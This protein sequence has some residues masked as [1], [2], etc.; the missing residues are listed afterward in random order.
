MKAWRIIEPGKLELADLPAKAASGKLV[1]IKLSYS[2]LSTT[3]RLVFDGNM[4]KADFPVTLGRQGVGMVTAAGDEVTNVSRGDRV[5]ADPYIVCGACACRA[6]R[7]TE[8]VALKAYGVQEDGFLSD[9]ALVRSDDLFKLPDRVKDQ[10]AVF[11]GHTALAMNAVSKLNLEKGEH[12]VIVGATAVG[13]ILAQVAMY[14]QAVPILVDT[15]ADRLAIAEGLGVYY[16]VNSVEEDISK[17]IFSLTG[18]RMAETLCYLSFGDTQGLNRSLEYVGNCGR[19]AIVGWAG[20]KPELPASFYKVFSRQLTV[21]GVSNGAKMIPAAINMLA[22]KRVE[23][24]P[25]VSREI[26]FSSVAEALKEQADHPHKY[27]KVLVKI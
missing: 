12:V 7:F 19:V 23:T 25:L 18:G 5:V 6:G 13:I 9:F 22:N 16:C 20:I 4:E 14:Y 27:L 26:P 3:D 10:E 24:A 21:Y 1:K 11:A 2:A 8:C 17:K 15:R